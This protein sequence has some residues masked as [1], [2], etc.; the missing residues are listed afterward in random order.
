MEGPPVQTEG[1]VE[2]HLPGLSGQ[3]LGEGRGQREQHVEELRDPGRARADEEMPKPTDRR[4]GRLFETGGNRMGAHDLVVVEEIGGESGRKSR[5]Q[6]A[7]A[8]GEDVVVEP[9][10]PSF[11]GAQGERHDVRD[12]KE[13]DGMEVGHP[14][15]V[16]PPDQDLRTVLGHA[17]GMREPEPVPRRERTAVAR[18]RLDQS[19]VELADRHAIGGRP[20][21]RGALGE[22][23]EDRIE[24]GGVH[25]ASLPVS[26]A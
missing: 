8:I 14:A 21:L 24:I 5:E 19:I 10:D 13:R 17:V 23:E 11:V 15:V 26:Y 6:I 20:G 4:K 9:V 1:Q 25:V 2:D 18:R 16:H 7:Q 12:P 3:S 22:R